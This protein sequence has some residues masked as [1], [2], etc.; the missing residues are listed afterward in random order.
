MSNLIVPNKPSF[1]VATKVAQKTIEQREKE[2]A[3]HEARIKQD[4]EKLALWK[5]EL[6]N[7]EEKEARRRV[8]QAFD[9]AVRTYADRTVTLIEKSVCETAGMYLTEIDRLTQKIIDESKEVQVSV[10]V[11]KENTDGN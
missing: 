3:V 9:F 8:E 5:Q 1:N 2:L 7:D 10:E 6:T 11:E 4:L